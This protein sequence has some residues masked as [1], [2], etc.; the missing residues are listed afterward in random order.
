VATIFAFALAALPVRHEQLLAQGC[1][2]AAGSNA[3]IQHIVLI[4]AENRSFDHLAGW[5]RGPNAQ[6]QQYAIGSN[7]PSNPRCTTYALND[8]AIPD[9]AFSGFNLPTYWGTA[10]GA[11]PAHYTDQ[12]AAF[13]DTDPVTGLGRNDGWLFSLNNQFLNQ[14]HFA[15]GYY[16][17]EST[18]PT[19]SQL[20]F[21][22]TLLSNSSPMYQSVL[23]PTYFSSMVAMS[24]PNRLYEH[25]GSTDRWDNTGC[26]INCSNGY[27]GLGSIWDVMI[28]P[29]DRSVHGR[30]YST[31][32]CDYLTFFWGD[33]YNNRDIGSDQLFRI[34]LQNGI[35]DTVTILDTYKYHPDQD[36]ESSDISKAHVDTW[37]SNIVGDIEASP[38]ASSTIVVITFDEGGG[39]FDHVV[40]PKVNTLAPYIDANTIGVKLDKNNQVPLG[41]RVPTIIVSP[42]S[43]ASNLASFTFDH[44]SVLKMIEWA[45]NYQAISG[46]PNVHRD[47]PSYTAVANLVCGLDLTSGNFVRNGGFEA[48][49]TVAG[50]VSN[51]QTAAVVEQAHPRSGRQNVICTTNG[52]DCGIY[53][54]VV[55]PKRGLNTYT[56]SMYAAASLTPTPKGDGR[57]GADGAASVAMPVVADGTYHQYTMRVSA[58]VV[59]QFECGCTRARGRAGWRST[60]FGSVH[61]SWCGSGAREREKDFGHGVPSIANETPGGCR[62]SPGDCHVRGQAAAGEGP[63]PVHHRPCLRCR[64]QW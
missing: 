30:Y 51:H 38:F 61:R 19:T 48:S 45:F 12:M 16:K 4:M 2:P 47:D 35:L 18:D 22:T 64:N 21:L 6:T 59:Q 32:C 37:L 20:P 15:I 1:S 39:F 33:K 42:Y 40:P 8:T 29:T 23:V 49:A 58:V 17:E 25:T 27:S 43:A 57:V 56:L 54:D 34:D 5:T 31:A 53:Q 9:C 60:M 41:F 7:D 28:D 36:L 14:S 62:R 3:G 55:A 26:Q 13:Y 50:W 46:D 10:D 52:S 11:D 24:D 44:A 63:G